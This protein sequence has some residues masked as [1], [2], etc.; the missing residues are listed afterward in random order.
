MNKTILL[1]FLFVLTGLV[2]C[3][4]NKTNYNDNNDSKVQ[5]FVSTKQ[6]E[7][8]EP[9]D[10][11]TYHVD[12][13]HKYEYRTGTSGDYEYNYDVVG[14]DSNGDDVSG[15]V[16]MNGKYGTGTITTPDGDEVDV[17]AEWV[18]YG[19]LKATDENGNEYELE[20]E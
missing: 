17:D 7:Y 9:Q 18:D 2:S 8:E 10:D 5:G 19:K 4:E 6:V 16:S 20:A 1:A 12:E 14:H 11:P 13:E 15:N 3:K